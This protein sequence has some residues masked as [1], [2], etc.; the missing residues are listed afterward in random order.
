MN[1][2]LIV[3]RESGVLSAVAT[4]A[5]MDE[6]VFFTAPTQFLCYDCVVDG[7]TVQHLA[8]HRESLMVIGPG[9]PLTAPAQLIDARY[10]YVQVL[11]RAAEQRYDVVIVPVSTHIQFLTQKALKSA[12][13]AEAFGLAKAGRF[14]SPSTGWYY[15]AGSFLVFA[16][17]F[18]QRGLS[19]LFSCADSA[20]GDYLPRPHTPAQ[21]VQ[22]GSDYG[23]WY[24]G[25]QV[26]YYT[27][28]QTLA[29]ADTPAEV[30]VISW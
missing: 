28:A 16:L 22:V 8:A 6:G 2:T 19:G 1:Y 14:L 4:P 11:P 3:N 21:I 13:L 25:L 10:A 29:N 24:E 9:L 26:H 5:Q 12:D 17:A 20:G 27:L 15:D 30:D 23:T 7:A 18:V